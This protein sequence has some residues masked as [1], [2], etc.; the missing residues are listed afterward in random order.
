MIMIMMS[1]TRL[2]EHRIAY[3]DDYDYGDDLD[4]DDDVDDIDYDDDD[5][6]DVNHPS[7]RAWDRHQL[8]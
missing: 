3:D 1:I 7:K 6:D 8:T 4:Y 5:D 2:K